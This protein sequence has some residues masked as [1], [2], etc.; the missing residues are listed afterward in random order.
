[1]YTNL[2]HLEDDGVKKQ[3]EEEEHVKTCFHMNTKKDH[4]MSKRIEYI[5]CAYVLNSP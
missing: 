4:K 2:L 5:K 1:M 3:Q